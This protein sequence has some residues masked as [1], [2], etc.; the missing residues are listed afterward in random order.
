MGGGLGGT[1][2]RGSGDVG[3][4][5]DEDGRGEIGVVGDSGIGSG[6]IVGGVDVGGAGM[7]DGGLVDWNGVEGERLAG[8]KRI[9]E[10]GGVVML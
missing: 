7:G 5:I 3:K 4:G 6:G 2:G 8:W 10:L 1:E 9:G